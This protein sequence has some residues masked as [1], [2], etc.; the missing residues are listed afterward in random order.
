MKTNLEKQWIREAF[1]R[2]SRT[3]ETE[4]DAVTVAEEFRTGREECREQNE[5]SQSNVERSFRRPRSENA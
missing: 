4:I 3:A 2:R 5:Q 1:E